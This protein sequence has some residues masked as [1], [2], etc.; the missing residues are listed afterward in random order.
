MFTSVKQFF[1]SSCRFK[2]NSAVHSINAHVCESRVTLL[3]RVGVFTA[4]RSST[5]PQEMNSTVSF[6]DAGKAS[7]RVIGRR[8]IENIS[9]K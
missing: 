8:Q 7:E 2:S 4:A 6:V 1:F 3:R 5:R 9:V